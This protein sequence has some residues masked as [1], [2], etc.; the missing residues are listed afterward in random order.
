M[1]FP[2]GRMDGGRP[3]R[4]AVPWAGGRSTV[5][6]SLSSTANSASIETV[7]PADVGDRPRGG[8]TEPNAPYGMLD[9][10]NPGP[11]PLTSEPSPP[12]PSSEPEPQGEATTPSGFPVFL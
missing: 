5:A 1:L 11:S 12:L 4:P 3:L 9:A 6:N 8:A 2:P 7:I 10:A